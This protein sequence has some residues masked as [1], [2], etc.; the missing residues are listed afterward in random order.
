MY[1]AEAVKQLARAC[2]G[3]GLVVLLCVD[4]QPASKSLRARAWDHL[5][6]LGGVWAQ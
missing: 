2:D 4:D 6:N 1:R 3:V 5:F